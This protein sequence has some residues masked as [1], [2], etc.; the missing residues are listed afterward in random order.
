MAVLVAG[1]PFLKQELN[2]SGGCGFMGNTGVEPVVVAS[3][4][5]HLRQRD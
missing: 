2:S 3:H 5:V 4:N 1:V